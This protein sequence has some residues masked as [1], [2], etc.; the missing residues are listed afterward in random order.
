M[1]IHV[2]QH[3]MFEGPSRIADWAVDR[4][5]AVTVS[6][7]YAGDPLP[8]LG[9]YDRLVI[10]GGPMGVAD[11]DAHSWLAPEKERIAGAIEAGRSVVGICLGAQLIAE[12]LGARVYRNRE[13]EIG[14]FPI[15]LTD[16]ARGT[17]LCDG[18]PT[19]L[20]AFHWHGDTFDLPAG[21]VQLA[22][23][24]GCEQQAFLYRERVLALQCHLEAT[25]QGVENLARHCANELAPGRYVQTAAQMQ[26]AAAGD[27]AAIDAALMTI[28]DRLPL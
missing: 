22:R 6:H 25:P 15:E 14:W 27:Y 28:L 5:H 11:E 12:A 2:L 4:G 24:E 10:M 9:S 26:A 16:A 20:T 8:A 7:L 1:R 17:G 21:A 3:V 18:L 19:R 23:S 13:R